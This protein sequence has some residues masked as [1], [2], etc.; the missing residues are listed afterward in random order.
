MSLI[1]Q[2]MVLGI[3]ATLTG[4]ATPSLRKL[5]ARNELVA[6]Q[7]DFIGALQQARA[8]AI[9]SRRQTLF[10]PSVDG[11]LCRESVRWESGWLLAHDENHDNQPDG[12]PLYTGGGYSAKLTIQSSSGRQRVRFHPN[13][14]AN[15]SNLTL[16]FCSPKTPESALIVVVSNAGRVRG[17][18]A[19]PE[20]IA[21]CAQLN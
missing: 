14:T 15:G 10:C 19:T 12:A 17:A 5:M 11:V 21:A 8:A 4:V 7:Y 18:R 2:I 3:I 6:A 1:E 20:Q 13:G 9:T 16:L